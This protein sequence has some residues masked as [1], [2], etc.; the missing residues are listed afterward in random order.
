MA[1]LDRIKTT[2]TSTSSPFTLS[3]SAPTGY[4][5]F[6]KFSNNDANIPVA[7]V[8]RD[9]AKWQV[10]YCTISSS[11][12]TLT[13]NTVVTN[14]NNNTTPV[15]FDAGT[16]DVFVAP[17]AS[18]VAMLRENNTF[19]G[20]NTFP[21]TGLKVLDTGADHTLTI[22]PNENLAADRTLN[23]V[24]GAADRTLTL[25]G[26]A[27]VSGTNTGDQS[28]F[29][30]IAVATQSNVVADQ[31]GD[32]LTLVAGANITITTDA[33]ADSITIATTGLQASDATLTALAAYNTN[34][35]ITQT[36]ADTFAGRTIA[37]TAPIA[38]TNGDGVSGN[39]T[40]SVSDIT[41]TQIKSDAAI[42]ATKLSFTQAGS[43][44]VARTVDSKLEDFVSL[45]DFGGSHDGREF[46]GTA[47]ITSGTATLTVSNGDFVSGDVGKL[48]Y[49]RGAGA[50][51]AVLA[52]TISA[53]TSAT[54][55]TLAANASTTVSNQ[56]CLVAS[57]D[58][59][60]FTA[61]D[62]IAGAKYL[63]T[64]LTGTNA[65]FNTIDGPYFG[66]GQLIDSSGNKRAPWS[67]RISA[68]PSRPANAPAH[69]G[70]ILTGFNGDISKV[71]I[72][73]EHVV[74][75]ATTLGQPT[76]GY[77]H[78]PETA[79]VLLD[80]YS[81]SGYNHSTSGDVGRTQTNA[82]YT[83]VR[84]Y[85]Q[86]DLVAYLA[87]GINAS[88][89]P[90]ATNW[91][92]NPAVG[93]FAADMQAGV[94]NCYLNPV[95][96]NC[97]G[98]SYTSTA[99]AGVFNLF[100]GVDSQGSQNHFWSGVRV[101]SQGPERADVGLQAFG[102]LKHGLD[103][104]Y[105][106]LDT[107]QAAI[108]LKAG[109]RIYGNVTASDGASRF[110]TALNGDY[111]EFQ[112]SGITAWNF[113][114]NNSSILQIYGTQVIVGSGKPFGLTGSTSGTTL[115]QATATASGTLTLPAATDT[116]VGR[117][118]TDTLTNKTL[119]SPVMSTIVNTGTLTL[120]TSTDTLV[121]RAT[122]DTLT[123]K[124]L[125]SPVISTIVNTGTLTLPTSTDT[126]VGRAT[127]DTLTNKTLASPTFSGSINGGFE[128]VSATAF[129]PQIV[130]WNRANDAN[131][132]FLIVRKSRG[133]TFPWP[134]VSTG[135]GLGS[136]T[137]EGFDTSNTVRAAGQLRCVV[138]DVTASTVPA[139]FIIA[140]GSKEF[141]FYSQSHATTSLR[142]FFRSADGVD[143]DN[144]SGE[145]RVNGTKVVGA[146]GAA[147]ADATDAA[148]TQARLNDLLARLR[149][150]GL[151]AT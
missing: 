125:T 136:V 1:V 51:G 121:G 119:T 63:P 43:G 100:R 4:F 45:R 37:G 64:G 21:N 65:A 24:V 109:Q 9:G 10:C 115:L 60:A 69:S 97:T 108:T 67:S 59:S 54:Q 91:S 62:A 19:T 135:D 129:N 14:H 105:A 6:D 78:N 142:G 86:G 98:N 124:T 117:A 52:T 116:L 144:A 74:T 75:G 134:A 84:Q 13:V 107:N 20:N 123:N 23:V 72:A 2:T 28:Q 81:D 34:G 46:F 68:P 5:A 31:A 49:V 139:R 137:F 32:T 16:H 79:A 73:M 41:N 132:A 110:P 8:Q 66:R 150:H 36:A 30:T 12:T 118:T 76:T 29:S 151:I 33:G 140:A 138:D 148:S 101:N 77:R 88:N 70:S 7:I 93:A 90:S 44:A 55:V 83:Q 26:D 95:E 130:V 58:N 122:T 89:N 25:T 11:G 3:T 92:A 71:Q 40:I 126:L 61:A 48:I 145:Y 112:T 96:I 102:L 146:Q 42:D 120:P 128:A 111:F 17:I 50:A 143:I 104:S 127:T 35:I 82:F 22:K 133:N 147:V 53:R 47:S 106:N 87:K 57:N 131:P 80:V 18:A 114:V 103:L 94:E 27:S 141:T 99:V 85:G 56:D 38:V 113:V 149:T 39:P 15:T